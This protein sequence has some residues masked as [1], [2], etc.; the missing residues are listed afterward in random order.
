MAKKKNKEKETTIE[1]YYDLKVDKVDDLVAALK[2]GKTEADDNLSLNISDC[3]GV[4]DPSNVKK[5]GKQKQFDPYSVDKLS[6]VPAW[7]KAIFIKFWFAGAVCYFIMMGIGLTDLDAIVLMGI[8]LGIVVD[9]LVNPCFRYFQSNEKEY[10]P[11]IMFPFPFKAFWTF[12]ANIIYYLIVLF[13]VNYLY[14]GVNT[15]INIIA[16][17]ELTYYLGVEPL[18]FGVFTLIVDMIFIGIKDLVV[19]LVR[20]IRKNKREIIDV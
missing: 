15:L 8:V 3:T 1:N 19:M 9:V 12:F 7:I 13:G 2:D 4:D 5:N 10:D 16:G 20:K 11:Y 17:T 14:L 18:V 6:R